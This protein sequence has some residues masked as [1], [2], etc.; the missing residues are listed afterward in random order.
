M[1]G[2]IMKSLHKIFAGALLAGVASGALAQPA[3]ADARDDKIKA[4]E[5]KLD[6]LV[7]ELKD[8]KQQQ[9]ADK[10]TVK[11]QVIDLKRNAASQY[12]DVQKQ[13]NED[14]K[15]TLAN[16][17]PTFATSDGKFSLSI[18]SLLQED[19][20]YYLQTNRA[21]AAA[22]PGPLGAAALT[23]ANSGS[24]LRR[25]RI[26]VEGKAFGDW[27]Y[28]FIYDFGSAGSEGANGNTSYVSNAYIQYDGIK[29]L[30]FRTGAYA[31]PV[32][33]EDQT[34]ASDLIFLER[35]AA[36]DLARSIAGSD[37]RK[38]FL[39]L[40]SYGDN[41]YAALSWTGAKAGDA[42]TFDTQ[43]AAVGYL[44]SRVYH[45]ANS[46]V[47]LA[48]N[49][50]YVFKPADTAANTGPVTTST[51]N[52]QER[53]ESFV[54]STR[55]IGIGGINA[56]KAAAWGV[57][58][59]GNWKNLYGQAG[60]FGFSIDRRNSPLPNPNFD[61]WYV[62]GSWVLTGEA[63]RYNTSSATWGAPRPDKPFS[64]SNP[65]IGAW[66]IA[67]RY[68]VLDLNYNEGAVGTNVAAV[69]GIRGGKE[70][71]A[72]FA[73]NWYPNTLIRLQMNYLHANVDR[74]S[75]VAPFR[76]VPQV[77]DVFTARAQLSF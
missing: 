70:K 73:L 77:F 52:F 2:K 13:R 67:A 69:G 15:V 48:A 35:A 26:G 37:G 21:L 43:Q 41:Y 71:M 25:A 66:E 19:S 27:S 28:S 58:A 34:S 76:S 18:R 55:V 3:L 51:I 17:R 16:G 7:N 11:N 10:E 24:V 31:T 20:A 57:E 61:G 1:T 59:A 64:L 63:R 72:T 74:I 9:A 75:T 50:T 68:S 54:D 40:I 65:G 4:L 8:L 60:Y 5:Q 42:L 56:R 32:G 36:A 29:W 53:L 46:N 62:Q 22:N 45:D 23:D 30:K 12:A 14:V 6:A 47:V 49:G 44:A 39:S 33:I 38:N